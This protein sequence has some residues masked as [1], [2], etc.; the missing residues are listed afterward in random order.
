MRNNVHAPRG[1][2]LVLAGGPG[3]PGLP[4]LDR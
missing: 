2:L 4:I 1:V 3:Q